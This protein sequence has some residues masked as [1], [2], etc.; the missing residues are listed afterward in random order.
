[1]LQNIREKTS[2]WIAYVIIGLISIPFVLAGITSYFGGGEQSPAAIVDGEEISVRQLD[3]A[4]ANYQQRLRDAFGGKIPQ[5]FDNEAVLKEQARDQLIDQQVL[6][7]Y[8]ADNNFRVGDQ[9]LNSKI[10]SMSIFHDEGKFSAETYQGQLRS[11]GVSPQQFEEDL[12]RSEEMSQIRRAINSTII[13]SKTRANEKRNLTSQQRKLRSLVLPIDVDSVVVTEDDLAKEYKANADRY[14]TAEK[15]KVDYIELDLKVIKAGITLSE[16]Q[17]RD[18]YEQ[19]KE[20]LTATEVRMA[21][22]ILIKVDEEA[23][24]DADAKKLI[25]LDIKSKISS[26]ESFAKLAKEYSDDPGSAA[27][28]GDLG[29]I[30]KGMMVAPFESALFAMSSG[31]VSEPI[32]TTFGWHIIKLDGISGGDAPTYE[33]KRFELI[34]LLKTEMA[35]SKIYELAENLSNLTYEQADSLVPAAEQ[36]N[37]PIKT[38]DW[39]ERRKGEGIADN[40]KVRELAFSSAILKEGRN[41]ETLEL[42]DNHLLVIHLN[43]HQAAALPPIETIRDTLVKSMKLQKAR[44]DSSEK[45]KQGLENAKLSGLE[46][47][48]TLWN[49]QIKDSGFIKRNSVADQNDIVALAFRMKKPEGSPSFQGIELSSGDYAIIE[50]SDIKVDDVAVKSNNVTANGAYE[51][52]AWLKHKVTEAKVIKTPLSELQ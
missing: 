6:L 15:I 4:Y 37:L 16:E 9:A 19:I 2:G 14:M 30:E 20:D 13:S 21:S 7:K 47:V 48:S 23:G 32:K 5:A 18:Y 41:S 33:D 44:F 34:D 11:Q 1:M 29:D 51:Y 45:G 12:R 3:Y 52:Q 38:T 27:D 17:I 50:V 42:G 8:V 10:T 24:D 36:L 39:F 28:G 35:E 49:Q 22:H 31:D 43:S 40:V 25:A 46:S 26:G